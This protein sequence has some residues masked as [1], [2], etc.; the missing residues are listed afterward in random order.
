MEEIHDITGVE[1]INCQV[2][3]I[4]DAVAETCHPVMIGELNFIKLMRLFPP[5]TF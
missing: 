2:L 1:V 4:I 3:F 5:L